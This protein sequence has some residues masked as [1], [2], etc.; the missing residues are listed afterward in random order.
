MFSIILRESS[1]SSLTFISS[2]PFHTLLIPEWRFRIFELLAA[3]SSELEDS[4][5]VVLYLLLELVSEVELWFC[6]LRRCFLPFSLDCL[7]D[8]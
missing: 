7:S 3:S 6:I 2:F 5:V 1:S 4:E 8:F